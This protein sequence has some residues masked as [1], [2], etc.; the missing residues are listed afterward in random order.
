MRTYVPRL[1]ETEQRWYL[2]DA[3]G[4]V[5]GRMASRIAS[6]LRGKH[7]PEFTPHLDLG[8]HVIVIN[9]EKVV[10]T[11]KKAQIKTYHRHSGYPGG[12]RTVSFQEM[13][14]KHPERI[15]Y[16]AVKGMLPRSRLGRRMLRKLRVYT[17]PTH[18]HQAQTPEILAV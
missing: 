9:A 17:G 4:K 15:V 7:R 10:L 3:E 14:E 13:A 18:P 8:D 6:V 1:G 12:M 5:L 16:L 2:V 11:G